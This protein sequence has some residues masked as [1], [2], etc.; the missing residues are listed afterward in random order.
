M[1]EKF[2]V[3]EVDAVTLAR[4]GYRRQTVRN[5]SGDAIVE[6]LKRAGVSMPKELAMPPQRRLG[7][8]ADVFRRNSALIPRTSRRDLN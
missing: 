5:S 8:V 6:K 1:D 3:R 4:A 2:L 7:K